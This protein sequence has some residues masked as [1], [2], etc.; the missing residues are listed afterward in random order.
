[1]SKYDTEVKAAARLETWQALLDGYSPEEIAQLRIAFMPDE[2]A[3]DAP[4]LIELGASSKNI[5]G[6]SD[7]FPKDFMDRPGKKAHLTKQ[8]GVRFRVFGGKLSESAVVF[9]EEGLQFDIAFLDFCGNVRQNSIRNETE[10]FMPV[11][12][13]TA[14]VAVNHLK[15]REAGIMNAI[16]EVGREAMVFASVNRRIKNGRKI[17]GVPR[18][19]CEPLATGEYWNNQSPMVWYV[20]GRVDTPAKAKARKYNRLWA[21]KKENIE[22][23]NELRRRRRTADPEKVREDAKKRRATDY[24]KVSAFNRE[25]KRRQYEKDPEKFR[26]A[27]RK[28]RATNPETVRKTARK[29]RV[30]NPEKVKKT[31]QN[32]WA[33]NREKINKERRCRRAEKKAAAK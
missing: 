25:S 11:M 16:E 20:W 29:Y 24:E 13:P 19:I 22:R 3:F 31:F 4:V 6:I 1:M 7:A 8:C 18:F 10:A 12:A 28:Y 23:G 17:L 14:R 15:G 26:E 21:A 33:K 2:N 5:V 30:A 32:W 27:V 9:E